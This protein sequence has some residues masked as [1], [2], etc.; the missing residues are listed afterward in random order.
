MSRLVELS[1]GNFQFDPASGV[2]VDFKNAFHG[3][4]VF[5]DGRSAG[6]VEARLTLDPGR[7]AL[8]A[9][10]DLEKLPR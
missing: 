4:P 1:I 7:V 10:V 8:F 5:W 3:K 2:A 9:L 6:E